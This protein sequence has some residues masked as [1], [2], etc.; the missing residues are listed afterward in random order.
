MRRGR[1]AAWCLWVALAVAQPVQSATA[2][3]RVLVLAPS[4]HALAADV[5]HALQ[6]RVGPDGRPLPPI[7]AEI[8]VSQPPPYE[9]RQAQALRPLL[10]SYRAIVASN[11]F[12]ARAIQIEEPN[13][14]IIFAGVGDP[15]SLCLVDSLQRPGRNATGYMHYLPDISPKMLELLKDGF[16]RTK[17][18][19]F[20]ADGANVAPLNCDPNDSA[21]DPHATS[22]CIGG[23]D[24]P[25]GRLQRL[26]ETKDI[27]AH[28]R[29]LGIAV[30]FVVLCGPD[31]VERLSAIGWGRPDVA[32]AV[33]WQGLFVDHAHAL[34]AA[35]A[36]T[37]H[38]AIYG[39]H[40]FA[41]L[42]GLLSVEPA[43]DPRGHRGTI[44]LLLQVLEGRSPAT[45][46]VQ[47][48]RGFDV[49]VNVASAAAQ[50][51]KPGLT[52]LRRA[53][54]LLTDAPP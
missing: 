39:R 24:V 41:Q 25:V 18:V 48:P 20:L 5:S 35:I 15:S 52:L 54:I 43:L 12:I 45:L 10:G 34:V 14:P 37:R 29:R 27:L 46:P 1:S 51:L 31:D 17:V 2:R 16:P 7:E 22:T 44:E 38:P 6:S 23:V 26:M 9:R 8:R 19:Y 4:G 13:T 21:W 32:F 40:R 28:A 49:M 33:P 36:R 42:G 53:D 50:G 3:E 30:R 47:M 11:Q